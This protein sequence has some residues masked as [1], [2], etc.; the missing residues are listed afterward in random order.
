MI[1]RLFL[2]FALFWIRLALRLRYRV[3]YR[4]LE[5]LT[6]DKMT[7]PGGV[8]FIPNHSAILVD[9]L[10][11]TLGLKRKV[12]PRPII[13]EYMYYLPIVH[14]IMR[15]L[16]ALPVPNFSTQI[17]SVKRR[18]NERIFDEVAE[19]LGR[20]EDFL[21]YPSGRIKQTG[22]ELLGSASGVHRV[23]QQQPDANV[24]LVHVQ[25][26]W[27]SMFSRAITGHSPPLFTTLFEG[28]KIIFKNLI[29]FTPRREVTVD[30]CLPPEDFP[31]NAPRHEFNR[32]LEKWYNRWDHPEKDR[33]GHVGEAFQSVSYKFW[34]NEV[35]EKFEGI[36]EQQ[37]SVDLTSVPEKIKQQVTQKI[38]DLKEVDPATIEPRMRLAYDLDMDSLDTAELLVFLE[39]EYALREVLAA[40]LTSVQRVMG[41]AAGIVKPTQQPE[42]KIDRRVWDR[43]SDRLTA[44]IPE[45]ESIIEAFLRTCDRHGSR[46]ACGDMISGVLTYKK[47]KM[48]VLVL[49]NYLESVE[50]RHVGVMLPASVAAN[51]CI[52]ACQLAGKVPVMV[53]WTMGRRHL[54][55]VREISGAKVILSSWSFID[56]LGNVELE[57]VEELLVMLEDIRP[58]FKKRW[59]L[60]AALY[61]HASADVLLK[62]YHRPQ[63]D[64]Q[65]V[66][67][68]TSG[69]ENL[70]KGVP[71]SHDN[72]LANLRA[73]LPL[74]EIQPNDILFSIL[75]PFHSFGFTVTGMLPLLAGIR[76]VFYPDPTDAVRLAHGA[77]LWKVT[78][79]AGAPTFLKNLLKAAQ[80]DKLESIRLVVSGAER[81]PADLLA[82]IDQIPSNPVYL[83]GYGITEC[84]PILTINRPEGDRIGV[85]QPIPG[86]DLTIVHPESFQLLPEGSQGLVLCRGPNVF[87]GYAGTVNGSPFIKVGEQTWYNTGDIGIIDSNTNLSLVGRY[88]RF[89][90][91]GGEMVSLAAIE[92]VLG[93]FA[94]TS[95]QDDIEEGPLLAV[96]AQEIPG[97][98]PRIRVMSRIDLALESVNQALREEGFSSLIRVSEV[99]QIEEIPVM[100]T[101]KIHYRKLESLYS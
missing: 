47:L 5:N 66:L 75:P 32:Y 100:G 4:G 93:K 55:T 33:V 44:Q 12:L 69:T 50:G 30:F 46:A 73:S 95:A 20:K 96:I 15:L 85:G 54:E 29:F 53:N 16:N 64:D 7:K 68:F 84:S 63:K 72:I 3:K 92:S 83:E 35:L 45:G 27:G 99:K 17:N 71:L 22:Y 11:V 8:L 39:E 51:V 74:I 36:Y 82:L 88:K 89:I 19:G 90:K 37:E 65:A 94:A 91:I 42:M 67:L 6:S 49:A 70:P 10:I 23:L 52:L 2:G 34:R 57:E 31:S 18:R 98:K 101:G 59:L 86:V 56:R 24:V 60:K 58:R 14:S 81:A 40:D 9:P 25:G 77:E 80:L 26:L 48:R 41:L 28:V 1:K 78:I 21:I 43:E 97:E 13:V 76:V 79:V 87:H 61:Q 38:A 62:M